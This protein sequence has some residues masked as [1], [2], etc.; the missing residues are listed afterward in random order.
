MYQELF[1]NNQSTFQAFPGFW[2]VQLPTNLFFSQARITGLYGHH[3]GSYCACLREAP[4]PVPFGLLLCT[5]LFPSKVWESGPRRLKNQSFLL[6]QEPILPPYTGEKGLLIYPLRAMLR[7]PG[8][9]EAVASWLSRRTYTQ[10]YLI[11]LVPLLI[12]S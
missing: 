5:C 11:L 2:W 12:T 3:F 8:V 4:R 6:I 1:Q 10:Q 7:S 9:C